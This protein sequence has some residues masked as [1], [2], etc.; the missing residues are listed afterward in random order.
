MSWVK[1][2]ITDIH[3]LTVFCTAES[4]LLKTIAGAL[5][6]F[7]ELNCYSALQLLLEVCSR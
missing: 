5:T 3:F 1:T 2:L 7:A 6:D 4:D